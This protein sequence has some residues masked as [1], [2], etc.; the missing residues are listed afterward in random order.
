MID[1]IRAGKPKRSVLW[2]SLPRE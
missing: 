1:K 2:W